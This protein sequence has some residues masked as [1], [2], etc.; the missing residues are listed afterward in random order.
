MD[1]KAQ[2]QPRTPEFSAQG[3]EGAKQY[4]RELQADPAT[5][6]IDHAGRRA[7]EASYDK[8]AKSAVQKNNTDLT[9]ISAG[10]DNVGGRTRAIC[11]DPTDA[12][13]VWIG[14]VTGGLFKSTN[15]GSLW[16][17]VESFNVHNSISSIAVLGNGEVYVATGNR[18]ENFIGDGLFMSSDNG[19]TFSRVQDFYPDPTF[20]L[21]NDWGEIRP[22]DQ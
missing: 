3:W 18:F 22:C 7:L 1:E 5:G 14:S 10:P 9:W 8:Y 19:A 17:P 4:Q 12:N 15:A 21:T 6:E 2:Y 11:T 16:E 20:S 13:T